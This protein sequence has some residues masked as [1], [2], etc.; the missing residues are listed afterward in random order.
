MKELGL[1]TAIFLAWFTGFLTALGL[2]FLLLFFAGKGQLSLQ[3]GNE[4]ITIST[5]RS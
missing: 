2:V 1:L 5:W 3:Y 4:V